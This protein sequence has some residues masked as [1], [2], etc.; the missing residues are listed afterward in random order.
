MSREMTP[1]QKQQRKG[2]LV[3]KP[4]TAK[5]KSGCSLAEGRLQG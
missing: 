2:K 4:V 5:A 3:K 1:K